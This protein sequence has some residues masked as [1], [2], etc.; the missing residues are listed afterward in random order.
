MNKN[1]S[2]AIS[3]DASTRPCSQSC[4]RSRSH[5]KPGP[6]S[7]TRA[8]TPIS[9]LEVLNSKKDKAKDNPAVEPMEETFA[10]I[11]LRPPSPRATRFTIK[12]AA[13]AADTAELAA[14]ISKHRDDFQTMLSS[15]IRKITPAREN[16]LRANN[17][18]LMTSATICVQ[19]AGGTRISLE[20]MYEIARQEES[21]ARQNHERTL[22]KS[23]VE[24]N[25]STTTMST[26]TDAEGYTVINRR[27]GPPTLKATPA[28]TP[29]DGPR[30]NLFTEDFLNAREDK[31]SYLMGYSFD[32]ST[33]QLT[34]KAFRGEGTPLVTAASSTST[35]T[36]PAR[37][38]IYTNKRAA[39][40]SPTKFGTKQQPSKGDHS[41]IAKISSSAERKS[42]FNRTLEE[43]ER[44]REIDKAARR[45]KTAPLEQMVDDKEQR[46]DAKEA[47]RVNQ[48]KELGNLFYKS[49]QAKVDKEYALEQDVQQA[50]GGEEEEEE[51]D[52]EDVNPGCIYS[53]EHEKE[54]NSYSFHESEASSDNDDGEE[55]GEGV[56]GH[57]PLSMGRYKPDAAFADD[58]LD[59]LH[60]I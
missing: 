9:I 22:A 57:S 43:L 60:E 29:R 45:A 16:R 39:L 2:N 32:P 28:S 59:W 19:Q 49:A 1:N 10:S 5:P 33:R 4:S 41:R 40:A 20:R 31:Q 7:S 8:A 17:V 42:E 14:A 47:A 3:A 18:A 53:R 15:L 13:I 36:S 35:A 51:T 25:E 30:V 46:S 21:S 38:S 11:A 27:S 26:I 24:T 50:R 48:I 23:L 58:S 52:I 12:E 54:D 56:S 44:S 6:S 55:F 34:K 37:M